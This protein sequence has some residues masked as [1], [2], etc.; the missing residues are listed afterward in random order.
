MSI[1]IR[2]MSHVQN[3]QR[4]R[5]NNNSALSKQLHGAAYDKASN[6]LKLDNLAT[7]R[8]NIDPT[9]DI[10]RKFLDSKSI[11]SKKTYSKRLSGSALAPSDK[12]DEGAS[13]S[14]SMYPPRHIDTTYP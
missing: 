6:R 7:I 13:T 14:L 4:L 11:T 12:K 10:Y 3:L 2:G 9:T 1:L 8:L 5:S